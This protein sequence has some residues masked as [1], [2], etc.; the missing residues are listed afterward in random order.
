MAGGEAVDEH[1]L[2]ERPDRQGAKSGDNPFEL[3][4]IPLLERTRQ[5]DPPLTLVHAEAVEERPPPCPFIIGIVGE[6]PAGEERGD[7]RPGRL[8]MGLGEALECREGLFGIPHLGIQGDDGALHG[9]ALGRIEA[10][11][12]GVIRAGLEHV[13]ELDRPL[14]HPLPRH[15]HLLLLPVENISVGIA[16]HADVAGVV[17]GGEPCLDRPRPCGQAE[18]GPPARVVGGGRGGDAADRALEETEPGC[19]RLDLV[20]ITRRAGSH[21]RGDRRDELHAGL[22]LGLSDPSDPCRGV[23]LRELRQQFGRLLDREPACR[24]AGRGG[25]DEGLDPLP[26]IGERGGLWIPLPSGTELLDAELE[27]GDIL[28]RRRF[29]KRRQERVS[30]IGPAGV[31]EDSGRRGQIEPRS[32]AAQ[33]GREGGGEIVPLGAGGERHPGDRP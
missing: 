28:P 21:A 10:G 3:G 14:R 22:R 18:P 26:D 33:L 16:A 20:G 2:V 5:R 31:G 1:A 4:E 23:G 12:P 25:A 7:E 11:E 15:F 8:G 30:E 9:G 13:G 6:F 19:P 27:D 29:R 17:L 32:L 24:G